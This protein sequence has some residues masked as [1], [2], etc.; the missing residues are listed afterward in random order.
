MFIPEKFVREMNARFN[1]AQFPANRSSTEPVTDVPDAEGV[2]FL[3][4]GRNASHDFYLGWDSEGN[5][6]RASFGEI[7]DYIW[8]VEPGEDLGY[9][10][11]Y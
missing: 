9:I 1:A 4:V 8:Q 5:M 2:S 11:H 6:W 3:R 7:W 10:G